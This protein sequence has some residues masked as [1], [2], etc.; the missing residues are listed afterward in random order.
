MKIT[1]EF[2][3]VNDE[4]DRTELEAHMQA[5]KMAFCLSKITDQIRSWYKYDNRET[6]PVDEIHEKLW[7][8]IS[9]EVD[10]ER[11]GY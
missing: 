1:F 3:T 4:F 8:I 10:M 7:D 2:N 9:S 5:E 6:I 11:L